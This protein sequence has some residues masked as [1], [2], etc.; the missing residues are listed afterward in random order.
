VLGKHILLTVQQGEASQRCRMKYFP[1][2]FV[3]FALVLV[4]ACVDYDPVR[5]QQAE[6]HSRLTHEDRDL[7]VAV[8]VVVARL[9]EVEQKEQWQSLK[10]LEP[11]IYQLA[12]DLLPNSKSKEG[13][14]T[15]RS[16]Y[17]GDSM[18][19]ISLPTQQKLPVLLPLV[20][21]S[22][23]TGARLLQVSASKPKAKLKQQHQ[24][25]PELQAG[26]SMFFALHLGSYRDEQRAIAG[27]DELKLQAPKVL[28]GLQPRIERVDLGAKGIF[29]R[30]KAGPIRM[31][32]DLNVKC[33]KLQAKGISCARAD[34]TGKDRG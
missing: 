30:L 18:P 19:K 5:S 21:S 7:R 15:L 14:E 22:P 6:H 10:P 13:N 28:S 31:E 11:Q 3:A 32:T 26:R 1:L 33:K 2:L 12:A 27:W 20:A 23:Y 16:R 4:S 8:N 29:M 24:P 9:R 34:F 25:P 17:L